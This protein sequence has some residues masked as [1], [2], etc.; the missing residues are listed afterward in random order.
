MITN[1][2]TR[3]QLKYQNQ[4]SDRGLVEA[5]LVHRIL[6]EGYSFDLWLYVL[7]TD[8]PMRF[9]I[10]YFAE[11]PIPEWNWSIAT[12]PSPMEGPVMFTANLIEE[13]A[14][15]AVYERDYY[16]FDVHRLQSLKS[17]APNPLPVH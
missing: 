8:F 5:R 10:D 17:G 12:P 14:A 13:I 16:D 1:K 3:M 2:Y 9:G 11:T 15:E 6:N 4:A 7:T